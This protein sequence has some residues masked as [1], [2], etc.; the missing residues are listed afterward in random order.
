MKTKRSSKRAASAKV[1]RSRVTDERVALSAGDR[2][3]VLFGEY[4]NARGTVEE[5]NGGRIVVRPDG[6]PRRAPFPVFDAT[7]LARL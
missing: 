5:V 3:R 2:V 6:G 4:G 1:S 7:N